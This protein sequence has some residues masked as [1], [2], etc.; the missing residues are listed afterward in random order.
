M[1]VELGL[2]EQ[3][4]AAVLEVINDGAHLHD[5]LVRLAARSP[6]MALITDAIS[7]TGMGDGTFGLGDQSVLVEGGEAWTT[8][9]A[10]KRAGSTLAMDTT[11][12]RAVLRREVCLVL[13]ETHWLSFSERFAGA[14][15]MKMAP[16]PNCR[17][18]RIWSSRKIQC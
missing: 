15:R 9:G 17:R 18:E 8:S 4:Y 2:V 3:R 12:R 1:L 13:H 16:H 5:S 14:A 6:Q 7:A 11:L 10:R